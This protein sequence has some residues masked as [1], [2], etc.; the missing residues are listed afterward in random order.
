VSQNEIIAMAKEA[1]FGMQMALLDH[2]YCQADAQRLYQQLERFAA[3]VAAKER[4]E[5]AQIVQD[6]QDL[7]PYVGINGWIAADA[8]K[9]A[10]GESTASLAVPDNCPHILWFDD[11]DLNPVVFAGDGAK[12]AALEAYRKASMQ[13]NAHLFV[14]IA[15]NSSDCQYPCAA[16]QQ[17]AQEPVATLHCND[18]GYVWARATEVGTRMR[19]EQPINLYTAPQPAPAPLSEDAKD[20]ARYRWLRLALADRTNNGKSHWFCSIAAGRPEELDAAIDAARKQG[21]V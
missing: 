15:V 11:Q 7:D 3:L 18:I 21:G 5:C 19:F 2:P 1:G 6:M 12:R 10:P 16:P 8:P 17:E 9:A 4:E 14:R 13:W 20:A